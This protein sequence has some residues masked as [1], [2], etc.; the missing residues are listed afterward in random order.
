[1]SD[2]YLNNPL[3]KKAYVPI[4]YTQ[5]QIEEVIKCS[6]DIN[7]FIKTYTKI[8]SLDR[9]LINFEMYPFQEDMSR[10]IADN[11]FTVI[12]T[13]RQA[14][15]TTTSAAV[16][17]WHAIFNDS[18]TIAILA[19][20]LST[21]REILSRVQ[22]GYENLPKWLQQGVVTWN[23]TNIELENGSQII[24]AST[25]SSAIRGFSCVTGNTFITICDDDEN[26]Y[27]TKINNLINKN[28]KLVKVK[29]N[30]ML[31]C[32]YKITNKVN[33]KIYVGFHK[34]DNLDDGYMGSGKLIKRAIKKYGIDNFKKEILK[35]FDNKE[36]AEKYE[37][38]IVNKDFTLR[39][40]TYNVAIGGNVRIMHGRNNGFYNKNHTDETKKHLSIKKT[41]IPN[42][43]AHKIVLENN[44][45]V[46][47]DEAAKKLNITKNV[48]NNIRYM[49]GDPSV[50]IHFE[51]DRLQH[52]AEKYFI[53]KNEQIKSNK[54]RLSIEA[55]KRFKNVP[56]SKEHAEKISIKLKGI[57][58]ENPQ[59]K[60]PEKIRKTAEKHRGMKRSDQACKN[61][62]LSKKGK[63]PHNKS[64]KYCYNPK[65][66]EKKLC[67]ENE[68]PEGWERGFA[69]SYKKRI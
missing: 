41:G 13:C 49:C 46:N 5:E 32:V 47:Y 9:G 18:Y 22:R 61:I 69:S 25:A 6:K 45:V 54:I 58:R 33:Q 1:M 19:N 39:E 40:D 60:C 29:R 31:Y 55:S 43:N 28:S 2:L 65:T 11:R 14:G 17:L 53:R 64:K 30:K 37:A 63:Q 50:K 21:A 68:I 67:F 66:L 12:K 36:D 10:T 7:Y 44:D 15:K 51:N 24:A 57:K 42:P 20:K 35:V 8:I 27:H 59:N 56:K 26:I 3:L 34:T 38:E 23:K 62:S 48:K 16:I 52:A 4:E